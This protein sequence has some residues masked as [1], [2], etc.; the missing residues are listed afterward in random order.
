MTNKPR[1][2]SQR[3]NK[4]RSELFLGQIWFG[5]KGCVYEC[6]N[7]IIKRVEI[8]LKKKNVFR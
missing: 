6:A 3:T 5:D 8:N 2:K 1:Q 4:L 7:R